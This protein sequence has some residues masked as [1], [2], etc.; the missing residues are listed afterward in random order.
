MSKH[1]TRTTVVSFRRLSV[2]LII[3]SLEKMVKD[4]YKILGLPKWKF[5]DDCIKNISKDDE[6]KWLL[7]EDKHISLDI[8]ERFKDLS[9]AYDVLNDRYKKMFYDEKLKD[10]NL[11]ENSSDCSLNFTNGL[12]ECDYNDDNKI[13]KRDYR[14]FTDDVDA[15]YDEEGR[16]RNSTN[17]NRSSNTSSSDT[18]NHSIISLGNKGCSGSRSSSSSSFKGTTNGIRI[19]SRPNSQCIQINNSRKSDFHIDYIKE[20]NLKRPIYCKRW[21]IKIRSEQK[22]QIQSEEEDNPPIQINIFL[23]IEK[24]VSGEETLET[25]ERAYFFYFK[26]Y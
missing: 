5:G 20:R 13:A 19:S 22:T 25:I 3:K 6:T 4:F 17:S 12:E 2:F 9:E 8:Q 7:D 21:I 26:K 11:W 10:F 14:K 15:G 16:K 1:L 24:L 23:T 18:S